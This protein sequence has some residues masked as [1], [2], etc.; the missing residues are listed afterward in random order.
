MR[1]R[2]LPVLAV[3]AALVFGATSGHA[4]APKPQVT[5][6]T[7]DEY[8]NQASMDITSI[9]WSTTGATTKKKVGKKTVTTYTPVNLVATMNL[10]AAPDTRPGIR[11]VVNAASDCGDLDLMVVHD[12]TGAVVPSGYT[13][14]N[15]GAI[16]DPEV[17]FG[18]T[19]VSWTMPLKT[20][21]FK[22]GSS[23][24][25]FDGYVDASEFVL[26]IM[27]TGDAVSVGLIGDRT[28]PGHGAVVADFAKGDVT[29]KI[30]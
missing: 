13:A 7:G 23:L 18:A 25:S 11:Y 19:S 27:G 28:L 1:R 9:L 14:C 6:P 15:D 26:G 3:T 8:S 22:V 30:G 4:A 21:P 29:W 2:N 17:T 20:L 24:S 10:A 12:P 16:V 5:D